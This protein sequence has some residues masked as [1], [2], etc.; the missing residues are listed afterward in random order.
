MVIIIN[1]KNVVNEKNSDSVVARFLH[2]VWD[3]LKIAG[4]M[5]NAHNG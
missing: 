3:M 2:I 5:W 1:I 4:K